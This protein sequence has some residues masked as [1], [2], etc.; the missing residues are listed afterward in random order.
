MK[1]VKWYRKAAERNDAEAQFKLGWCYER[2]QGVAKDEV[3]AVKWYRKAAEQNQAAAQYNLGGCYYEGRGVAKDE[4]EAV[5]W[6]RKAAEQNYSQAQYILGLC[7]YEGQGATKDYVEAV[8][9]YRKAAAQNQ[10]E[11]QNNLGA[12]CERGEG[13]AQDP[14]AA[15]EWYRKAAAQNLAEAQFSLGLCYAHAHGVTK[16][17]VEAV[18]W[19][20]K[21]AEQNDAGAQN[22]LGLCYA[23]GQGVAKDYVEA[24]NWYRK[25]AAQ[26]QAEA[27][28][29]LGRCY[30]EGQG[31]AKDYVEAVRWYRKA[32]EQNYG[33]A[34]YN[35]GFCYASG[36]GVAKD[37]E[38]AY[39]WWLLAA[40]QGVEDAKRGV[41]KLR[42]RMSQEQIAE[43]RKLA[44]DFKPREMHAAAGDGSGADITQTDPKS[45]GT[46]FFITED[47]YLI[48][49]EHLAGSG[50]QVRVVTEA[51]TLSAKVITVDAETD[52]ALL[53][54]EGKF[55]ALPVGASRAV[56]MGSAVAT[57]GFPN[58]GLQGFA[59]ELAE[60]EIAA[61]S[62]AQ[63]DPKYFQISV[64]VQPGNSGGALV[65]EH[66]NV[67][68]V[69]SAKLDVAAAVATSEVLPEQVNYAVK[70][71]FLLS[72]LESV[73]GVAAK[74]KAP[75]AKDR[76]FEDVVSSAE[77]SAVLVLV[78]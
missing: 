18:K 4:Q 2:G 17:D 25:D 47:G 31:V 32:A 6:W 27:Q 34:Q 5:K 44:Q 3:E 38:E 15:V 16:D 59:P 50:A 56:K 13:V 45:S 65:D 41:T 36:A 46:G 42:G 66:G 14:V 57:V 10:A 64:P 20:R 72:F 53:K 37:Y 78:Y 52:L 30:H 68:G 12:C 70:S 51:G 40:R 11:A 33:A 49:N 28:T 26:N 69:V 8:N 75:N 71:C 23:T 29:S 58:I 61:F 22:N 67:V 74:L 63:E 21:A 48:T 62:G 19:Y 60:G 76:K 73:P 7:Y 43:G 39:K 1:A 35:L 55:A 54:V 24:V 77:K 9:W